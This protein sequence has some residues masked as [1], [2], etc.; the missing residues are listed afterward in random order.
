MYMLALLAIGLC[1]A[2]AGQEA[3]PENVV[4]MDGELPGKME[5]AA[6]PEYEAEPDVKNVKVYLMYNNSSALALLR[7]KRSPAVLGCRFCCGCCPRMKGCGI[8]CRF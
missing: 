3:E 2:E 5:D 8:C 4:T 1:F 7:R 6:V